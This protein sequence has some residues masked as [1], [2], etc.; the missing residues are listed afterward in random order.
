[1]KP[2]K[3][4]V[5]ASAAQDCETLERLLVLYVSE[6]AS[7]EERAAVE[8]HV[9]QCAQ[10]AATL[11]VELRLRRIL[12]TLPQ[13]A[14]EFGS[15]E[16]LLAQCRSELAEALDDVRDSVTFARNRKSS[17][18]FFA[19]A[20]AWCR[21][22]MTAHP[23]MGA[24]FFVLVG[25]ATGRMMPAVGNGVQQ[26]GLIPTMTVSAAPA[27]SDQQLQNMSVSGIYIA[28]G[29][30]AG[31]QNVEIHLRAMTPMVVAGASDDAEVKRVL[32]AVLQNVQKSDSDDRLNSV[33]VLRSRL[34]DA[35]V[36]RLLCDVA[37]QDPNPGV[38]L[39]AIEA[40]RG[41][42][43]DSNVLNAELAAVV[44]DANPGVRIEAENDLLAV[45]GSR[46]GSADPQVVRVLRNLS[47]HDANNYV[48]LQA[49]AAIR[50]LGADAPH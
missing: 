46:N 22:G 8:Q 37:R 35:D 11:A 3:H 26:A 24:A 48:R 33:E 12:A 18:G 34:A 5:P 7:G 50:Q 29:G 40:L 41:L 30:E 42:E 47:E 49:A 9:G 2:Q 1:M 23:A 17:P 15:T 27:I 4:F 19:N 45:V 25:L 44:H 6:E 32:T 39:R 36:R 31:T 14:D 21:M 43:N 13:A 16:V 28:P 10:C 38:R 20:I